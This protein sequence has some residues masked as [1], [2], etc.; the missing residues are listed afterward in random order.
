MKRSA[1]SLAQRKI[2]Q[3][4]VTA[5]KEQISAAVQFCKDNSCRGFKALSSGRYPLVKS[6]N[7][8]NNQLDGVTPPP[9]HSKD[10]CSV[11]TIDEEDTLVQ[12]IVSKNRA[13]QSFTRKDAI[14]FIVSM[15]K[16]RQKVNQSAKS[17]KALSPAAKRLLEKHDSG[18]LPKKG[19][20]R[21]FWERFYMK[22]EERIK[23]SNISSVTQ[24]E[25]AIIQQDNRAAQI[26][27]SGNIPSEVSQ[28]WEEDCVMKL[29]TDT[30]DK[31][32]RK[33]SKKR[34]CPQSVEYNLPSMLKRT[35][36]MPNIM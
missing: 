34:L 28:H 15:L 29:A 5:K 17:G 6:P 10:Y 13:N 32:K 11:I 12:T 21:R 24:L 2:N 26:A 4:R 23:D 27:D 18:V 30:L 25:S 9:R 20:L 16:T 35:N 36:F 19:D 31:G 33:A 1:N 7:T 14:R 8:I 22:H 3:Q